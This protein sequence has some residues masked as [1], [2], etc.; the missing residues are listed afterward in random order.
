MRVGDI[1]VRTS[2]S[3]WG[4]PAGGLATTCHD[5]GNP[6][7][8]VRDQQARGLGSEVKNSLTCAAWSI[9]L[10]ELDGANFVLSLPTAHFLTTM[11]SSC[12]HRPWVT[13]RPSGMW[14]T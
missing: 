11:R 8:P 13:D 5:P 7:E 6:A 12:P 1:V 3:V 4:R 9:N 10:Q 2:S 14:Q